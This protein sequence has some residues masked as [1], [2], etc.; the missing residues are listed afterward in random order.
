MV[1]AIIVHF[2]NNTY[3]CAPKEYHEYI[4]RI[5]GAQRVCV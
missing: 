4:K 1:S 5:T 3:I 2:F